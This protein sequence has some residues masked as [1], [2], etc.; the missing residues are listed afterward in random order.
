MVA[1]LP[2]DRTT[3]MDANWPGAN[4][5]PSTN[6]SRPIAAISRRVS[7]RRADRADI[8]SV[9]GLDID[10]QV[11]AILQDTDYVGQRI[12]RVTTV[13]G[14]EFNYQ[15]IEQYVGRRRCIGEG[16]TVG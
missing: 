13:T 1:V 2:S 4:M 12:N 15:G 7:G 16:H 5:N 10:N 6:T 14:S 3:Y 8:V 11:G 9:C